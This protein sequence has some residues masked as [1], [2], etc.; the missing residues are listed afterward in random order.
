MTGIERSSG[1]RFLSSRKA[2]PSSLTGVLMSRMTANGCASRW[3]YSSASAAFATAAT[4]A[5]PVSCRG[6]LRP[7]SG[8]AGETRQGVAPGPIGSPE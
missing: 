7:G 3:R 4:S 1:S 8:A 6:A 2:H 5:G